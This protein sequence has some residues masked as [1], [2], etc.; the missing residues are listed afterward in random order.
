MNSLFQ[1]ATY[2]LRTSFLMKLLAALLAFALFA[3]IFLLAGALTDPYGR[4]IINGVSLDGID[5][6]GMTKAEAEGMKY[7]LL[8]MS[9]SWNTKDTV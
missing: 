4:R 6:S 5:L 8:Y 3:G 1:K 2:H 9:S 7:T